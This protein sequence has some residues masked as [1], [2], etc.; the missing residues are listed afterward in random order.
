M[1]STN[2]T[3]HLHLNQYIGTDIQEMVDVNN[4]NDKI[5]KAFLAVSGALDYLVERGCGASQGH[6]INGNFDIWQRGTSQTTTGY[7]SD[8]RW[9]NTHAGATKTHSRQAFTVGQSDVPG[10]PTYF[11]TTVV[12]SVAGASNR[13]QKAQNIEDVRS[14]A[15]QIITV[16]FWAKADAPRYLALSFYQ[17]FGAG[18][19]S[20]EAIPGQKVELTTAWNKYNLTFNI[21]SIFGKT[22]GTNSMLQCVFWFD[23]GSNF[24]AITS[25]LGHQS[26]TFDIAQ[27]KLEEG[28]VATPFAPRHMAE[29]LALCQRY[30]EKSYSIDVIP[31]TVSTSGASV[32]LPIIINRL[33]WGEPFKVPK[34]TN[35]T[36]TIYSHA[37]GASARISLYNNNE[38]VPIFGMSGSHRNLYLFIQASTGN[39]VQTAYYAHWVADSEL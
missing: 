3:Q 16:S 24:N 31:G 13:C 38:D 30:Y 29:E 14:C 27:V 28:S 34:R 35:P 18:G 20:S 1:P 11:S 32:L 2:K 12:N 10:N 22:I 5:D 15:G 6:I 4:D 9:N 7:G 23:A 8:D 33:A 39:F 25:S 37:T 36:I 19:S 17:S 21:P 26:G